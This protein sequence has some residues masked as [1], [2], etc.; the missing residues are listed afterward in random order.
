M[1]CRGKDFN[2]LCLH[3]PLCPLEPTVVLLPGRIPCHAA[4]R[5]LWV[6]GLVLPELRFAV[7]LVS[8]RGGFAFTTVITSQG[9]CQLWC[10]VVIKTSTLKTQ[11]V[12]SAGSAP[13]CVG[14]SL[15]HGSVLQP[16]HDRWV[17]WSEIQ[18]SVTHEI[19]P[20]AWGSFTLSPSTQNCGLCSIPSPQEVWLSSWQVL[21]Q[22]PLCITPL[23]PLLSRAGGCRGAHLSPGQ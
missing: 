9:A 10:S 13:L 21:G 14:R 4:G 19:A 18:D 16:S 5:P 7:H 12:F 20:T 22:A 23:Q 15:I 6:S 11:G 1:P 3:F 2:I 17:G 8:S